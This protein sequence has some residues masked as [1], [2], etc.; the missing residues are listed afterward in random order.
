[1]LKYTTILETTISFSPCRLLKKN[2]YWL[3]L[4]YGCHSDNCIYKSKSLYPMYERYCQQTWKTKCERYCQQTW[5]T[6]CERY[7]QQTRK[8]MCERYCQQTWKTKCERYCQQTWK[9]KCERYCQQTWKTK[10]ERYCQQTRKTM[11]ERYCQQTWKTKC[12]RYCQ[13]TWKT[14]TLIFLIRIW[15]SA[16]RL[17][18]R[19]GGFHYIGGHL[20]STEMSSKLQHGKQ[21]TATVF[22]EEAITVRA[23]LDLCTNVLSTETE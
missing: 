20:L 22:K 10:C 14:K 9:T 15:L 11:C 12:E 13:Q 5:K 8:T 16:S 17:R 4:E 19:Y 1:M 18:L 21:R 3:F 7:C 2:E 23:T 6:K